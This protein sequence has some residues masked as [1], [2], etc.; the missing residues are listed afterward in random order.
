[1][2]LVVRRVLMMLGYFIFDRRSGHKQIE[3]CSTIKWT[4]KSPAS[5]WP[6]G[7]FI[8]EKEKKT[9]ATK[10][11]QKGEKVINT[12]DTKKEEQQQRER[13]AQGRDFPK[14]WLFCVD[15][16]S[17][18]TSP[19]DYM[20]QRVNAPLTLYKKGHKTYSI[21]SHLHSW[22]R[23]ISKGK[24]KKNVAITERTLWANFE[25]WAVEKWLDV[26]T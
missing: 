24:K 9:S 25:K 12:K 16:V 14:L 26:L 15:K 1:M 6:L 20:A 13:E 17:W 23:R 7:F 4:N 21:N 11:K 18:N 2:A 22:W 5:C 8:S 19:L 10:K 3:S